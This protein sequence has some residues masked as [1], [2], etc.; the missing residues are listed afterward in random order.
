M[1]Y[2][3]KDT[4]AKNYT[5]EE[6]IGYEL[7]PH[8]NIYV[9]VKYFKFADQKEFD[10]NFIT[11]PGENPTKIDFEKYIVGGVGTNNETAELVGDKNLDVLN[12]SLS[13]SGV[14]A[15]FAIYPNE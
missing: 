1:Q 14:G 11:V 10:N 13:V 2:R 8:V 7:R 12:V 15:G 4:S 3:C 6:V 5:V 9:G